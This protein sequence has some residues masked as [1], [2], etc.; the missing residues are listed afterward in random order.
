[1]SE[2]SADRYPYL[3]ALRGWAIV[4]VIAVHVSQA[5]PDLPNAARLLVDQGARGVQLF[6]VVSALTLMLSWHR[7]NDGVA[8]FYVRRFFRIA[9]VFWIA[10]L[11]FVALYGL[12]PRYW[13]PE[14][15]D[16]RHIAATASFMHGW[17]PASITSV[18]P[19]GWT[20]AVE[21]TFYAIFPAVAIVCGR[22]WHAVLL[23]A[24]TTALFNFGYSSDFI[25]PD[26]EPAYLAANFRMLWI[27]A[28]LPIF[29]VG[30]CVFF[31]AAQAGRWP[32]WL[33]AIIAIAA[34]STALALPF[35]QE[36]TPYSIVQSRWVH[37]AYGLVFGLLTIGLATGWT[38]FFVSR[39]LCWIGDRS[40]SAYLWHFA[41]L[42]IVNQLNLLVIVP[43]GIPAL[44]RFLVY[45]ALIGA[46]TFALSAITFRLIER[47]MIQLGSRVARR[48]S[49]PLNMA[50]KAV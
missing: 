32:K 5:V 4:G 27:V 3:S 13:A 47:P 9:P 20:I 8:A 35:V 40:F 36:F 24:V 30:I 1:M 48:V 37:I 14:G 7:R 31:I 43:A 22:W 33:G 44:A 12:G 15:I 34:T 42:S 21:M 11:G 18:V 49:L 6:F 41:I 19:G 16:W 50:A 29:A 2:R 38:G 23:F 17:H 10:I 46:G 25:W 26:Y 45:L 39:V 28:Q